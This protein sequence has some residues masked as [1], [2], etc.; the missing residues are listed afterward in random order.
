MVD[1]KSF[2]RYQMLSSFDPFSAHYTGTKNCEF[3]I[4]ITSRFSR[5]LKGWETLCYIITILAG[6]MFSRFW[7]AQRF[8]DFGWPNVFKILAGPTFSWTW[9]DNS[10]CST[11][12]HSFSVSGLKSKQII[13]NKFWCSKSARLTAIIV[14]G[15]GET[16]SMYVLS[17]L[18]V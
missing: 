18:V 4:I 12:Q 1:L 11:R 9:R 6:P 14:L 13:M 2:M 3:L 7:L 10:N 5:A 15:G 17:Y 16:G 8:Q